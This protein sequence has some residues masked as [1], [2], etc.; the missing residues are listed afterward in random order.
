MGFRG[1]EMDGYQFDRLKILVVDD[2]PHM[3]KLVVTILQAF[4]VHQI[5]EAADGRGG[6]GSCSRDLQPDII[7][8]DWMMDGMTG[9]ELTRMIRTIVAAPIRSC[10]SS[11]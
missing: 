9:V 10:R 2:N 3:R 7:F 1:H 8:L 11:C 4:G 6:L 5:F